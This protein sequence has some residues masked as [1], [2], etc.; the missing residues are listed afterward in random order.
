VEGHAEL[1]AEGLEVG[2]VGLVMDVLHADMEGRD[3]E[4]GD[5]HLGAASQELGQQERVLT[6][7][8]SD[9]DMVTLVDEL[10]LAQGF[11]EC[12]PESFVECHCRVV[13]VTQPHTSLL[14]T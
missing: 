6:T 12:L 2:G 9:E 11:V 8:Q 1:G 5:V 4:V 7:R 13:A 3:G 10:V 14:H